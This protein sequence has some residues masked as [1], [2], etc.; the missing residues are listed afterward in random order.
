MNIRNLAVVSA[1][2]AGLF[3]L[4]ALLVP[5]QFLALYGVDFPRLA[6]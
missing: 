3:G 5:A 6:S 1:V 2:V 4:T